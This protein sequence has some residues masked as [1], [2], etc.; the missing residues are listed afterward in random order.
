[1]DACSGLAFERDPL[2]DVQQWATSTPGPNRI[3]RGLE[4]LYDWY[5]RNEQLTSCV[6]RDAE[7]HQLTREV[8]EMRMGET[9]RQMRELLC[10]GLGADG[11]TLIE[12]AVDFHCWRV[13]ARSHSNTDAAALM[14]RA[15]TAPA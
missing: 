2:P 11:R 15:A 9:F 8:A 4:E 7:F 3:R 13:L 12:L 5:E 6:L 14:A 10:E 1:M